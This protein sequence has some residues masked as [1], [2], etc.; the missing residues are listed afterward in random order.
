MSASYGHFDDDAREYVITDPL[1]PRPYINYL[2]NTRLTAFV[3]QQA[4][5]LVYHMEP[6]TRRITRYH[7]L[8][9]PQDR[10]GFYVYVKDRSTGTLFNPHHAPTCTSLDAYECRHGLGYSTFAGEKDGV[11][12][13]V[14]MFIPP[15][16]DIFLWDVRIE[17][18]T[19][20]TKTLT[21][22]SYVE[23][24]LLEYLREMAA[25][26]Y[27]KNQ[28]G[29][30]YEPDKNWIRY[31]YHVFEA[32]FSPAMFF[33]CTRQADAFDCSR[34][35]FCGRGGSIDRPGSLLGDG[36]SNSQAPNGD[37][38]C[39]ALGVGLDLEPGQTARLAYMLGV[40][41]DWDKAAALRAKFA[42][43]QAVAAAWEALG[44][45]WRRRT[46]VV[47]VQ[48]GDGHVDRWVNTWGVANCHVTATMPSLI[49]TDHTGLGGARYRDMMQTALSMATIEP[50]TCKKWVRLILGQQSRDGSGCFGFHPYH[51]A[52]RDMTPDRSDNNVWPIYTIANLVGEEGSLD[53]FA[54]KVPFFDGGDASVYDHVLLGLRYIFARRGPAGLPM[55]AHADWNDSLAIFG[56]PQAQSVMLG[57]QMVHSLKLLAGFAEKLGKDADA[58]WC[59]ASAEELTDALNSDAVW[60][61]KWYRRLLLTSG[62]NLGSAAR[63]QGQIYLNPQSWSVISGVGADGRGRAAMD[64]ARERL[65]TDRGLMIHTPPYTGFPNPHDPITSSHPGIGEN[66]GIFCHANTWAII[67]ECLL[68]NGDRAFEYYRKLLPSVAAEEL[69]AD[70]WGREPYAF[71]SAINGP[72]CGEA[73]GQGGISWLTGTASW[74]HIAATQYILG[75]QP[76]LEGLRIRPC[77]PAYM[78]HVEVTRRFRGRDYAILIRH[79]PG[80]ATRITVNGQRLDGNL[81]KVE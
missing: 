6:L 8:P 12:A 69:G 10:P 77:L 56:D 66:G 41:D 17:N 45:Q 59:R 32:P 70:R 51:D 34:D 28:T 65:N 48:T 14:Q 61:G 19:E 33:A 9:S 57:M 13:T 44:A 26:C 81:L 55:I 54:E 67:A 64:Q 80:S 78:P 75:L 74:M 50:E 35:A 27:L 4:G 2:G 79:E 30:T 73:F 37:H 11:R 71:V 47:D 60:D 52:P 24:A 49:S 68:G 38:A 22:A 42:T 72:A 46:G 36:L 20:A 16:D 62:I 58:A 7:Y 1:T 5:G 40:A 63:P 29:V 15:D 39:G 23:F 25:W 76:V 18:R 31:V 43:D 53:F 21:V 3:S